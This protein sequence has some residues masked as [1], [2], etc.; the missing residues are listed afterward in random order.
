MVEYVYV[1]AS[2]AQR[3][4]GNMIMDNRKTLKTPK[5]VFDKAAMKC[6]G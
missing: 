3:Y 1:R 4:F 2:S 6:Y 5:R